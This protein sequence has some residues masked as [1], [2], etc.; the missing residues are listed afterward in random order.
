MSDETEWIATAE[1]FMEGD[2][3]RWTENIWSERKFG[4]KKSQKPKVTGKQAVTGQIEEIGAEF[5]TIKVLAAEVTE[6]TTAKTRE[7]YK[8]AQM[9]RKK[10][11]TLIKGNV[12]RLPWSDE[13]ARAISQGK[14][15]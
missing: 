5:I 8:P 6:S 12:E 9:I 14:K 7:P 13:E 10:A 11:A 3:I 2:V 1:D 15:I 4:R